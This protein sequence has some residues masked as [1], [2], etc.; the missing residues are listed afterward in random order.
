MSS[1]AGKDVIYIDIDDEITAIIDKVRSAE[2]RIVALVLPK[3]ATVL[4]SVVN[5]KLLKRTAD[6]AKKH[7]VLITNETSLLPL[8]GAVG[9]HVAKSLQSKPEIP[10]APAAADNSVEEVEEPVNMGDTELD[11]SRPIGDYANNTETGAAASALEEEPIEFDNEASAAEATPKKA[12]GKKNKGFKIPDFNKFRT[13]M[14]LGGA[15]L[16]LLIF[17][18]YIGFVVM[19]R[20]SITV[21]TDSSAI[22]TN[23]DVTFDTEAEKVDVDDAVL[24]AKLQQTQKTASQQVATTGE[25]D[26]GTKATGEVTVSLQDC[27]QDQ[28]TIPAGTGVSS[29]GLTFITQQSTTLSSVKVGNQCKT[30]ASPASRAIRW[31]LAPRTLATNTILPPLPSQSPGI[32]M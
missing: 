24:P 22:N 6:E 29:G 2:Q 4:Q 26:K 9:M 15:A 30:V 7:L 21:K 3:R 20:A 25:K 1:Q 18:W 27:S 14:V 12:K 19:P 8:A 11:A 5:M 17:F 13:W 10:H 31:V 16:V 23:L 32:P 28:V